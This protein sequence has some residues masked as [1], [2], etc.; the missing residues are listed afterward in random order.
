ML[1]YRFRPEADTSEQDGL[2]DDDDPSSSL[3]SIRLTS[4]DLDENLEAPNS[5]IHEA[6]ENAQLKRKFCHA[7]PEIGIFIGNNI[8]LSS[9]ANAKSSQYH[10]RIS[11]EDNLSFAPVR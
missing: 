2:A 3:G 6:E 4:R 5:G 9:V 7:N 1:F 11:L 10:E 8:S